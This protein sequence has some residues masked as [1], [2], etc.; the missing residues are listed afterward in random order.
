MKK[1]RSRRGEGIVS[2]AIGST[3]VIGGISFL[4]EGIV[5]G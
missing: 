2:G 5:D 1:K 4:V 3:T